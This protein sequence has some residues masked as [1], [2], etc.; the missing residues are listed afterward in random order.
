MWEYLGLGDPSLVVEGHLSEESVMG[1][2]WM[3]L[4]YTL[5]EP[6]VDEGLALFSVFEPRPVDLP[7]LGVV[8]IPPSPKGQGVEV[9][10]G[11]SSLPPGGMS[12]SPSLGG[13]PSSQDIGKRPCSSSSG[14]GAP[15]WKRRSTLRL[16][17][18]GR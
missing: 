16:S 5:G 3:V 11:S 7:Y 2:T 15:S 9:A 10:F 1:I 18:G 12:P 13:S 8:P 6:T 14:A 17:S 4:G